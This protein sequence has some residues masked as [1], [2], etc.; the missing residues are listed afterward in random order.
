M[1]VRY[2]HWM[3]EMDF[4]QSL[5]SLSTLLA[6]IIVTVL[7]VVKC[8]Y[9]FIYRFRVIASLCIIVYLSIISDVQLDYLNMSPSI[10]PLPHRAEALSDAFVWCLSVVYIGHKLRTERPRKTKIGTE[11]A[12]VTHDSDTTFKVKGQL[13]ADVLNSQHA[14]TGATWWINTK[15]VST[16]RGRRRHI[17][18]A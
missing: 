5:D 17:V 2:W 10:M 7:I 3:H 11:V 18:S 1:Q 8:F 9:V 4:C 16:C 15:I 13:V 6:C 12:H 14:G